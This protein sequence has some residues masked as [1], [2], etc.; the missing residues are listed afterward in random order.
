MDPVSI[1]I[2]SACA[3]KAEERQF[4]ELMMT[5]KWVSIKTTAEYLGVNEDTLRR[6]AGLKGD[7]KP[8]LVEGVEWQ[9]MTNKSALFFRIG[10]TEQKLKSLA[11]TSGENIVKRMANARDK[12]GTG[13]PA[14]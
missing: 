11:V 12:K 13:A 10:P 4:L 5:E 6:Y 9:R 3:S 7:A 1:A 14:A 2:E 8:C